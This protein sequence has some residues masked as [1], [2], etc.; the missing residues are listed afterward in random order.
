MKKIFTLA[1][2]TLLSLGSAWADEVTIDFTTKGYDNAAVV[3]TVTQDGITLTFGKG[4]SNNDPKYYKTGT[5]IR[6]YGGNTMKVASAASIQKIVFTFASGEGQ[7]EITADAGSFATDTWTGQANEVTFTIGGTSGHR[8]IQKLVVTTGAADANY[9]A[10]PEFSVAAGTYY[11]PQ[12]VELTCDTEGAKILYTIP[13]GTTDPAY[14]DDAN[15][16]GV[17]YDGTP[18]T[19]SRTTTIK[20]MAVKD[21]KTSSIVTATYTIEQIQEISVAAALE[22][23][24]GL[25]DGAKTT[26]Q[27][28]VKG[29]IVGTPDFQRN[30][31][32]VLYG[33]V[34]LTIA[35]VKGGTTTLTV[36][37]GKNINN[38]A[39][40]EET[41]S[42]LKEGDEVVFQGLLQKYMKNG[43]PAP[44][45]VS[46]YLVSGGTSAGISTLK[47]AATRQNGN[48]YNMAGQVVNRS[49][50]GLVIL[51]GKKFVN[52]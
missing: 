40:T 31:D 39:F 14:T 49:Y 48:I 45:L 15:Y 44:Q 23:I 2:L 25:G 10:A 52:K 47:A 21:G 28:R 6:C 16:T 5:A 50:K 13:D 7:N 22:I 38:V 32:G 4:S 46:G 42:S 36:Y 33:N 30:G 18:L 3:E 41:I 43:A 20:A 34:N 27:Y 9:V 26:D 37:R 29:F 19:I 12:T 24:N 17:F 1:L 35:D 51:N 11:E 8:R